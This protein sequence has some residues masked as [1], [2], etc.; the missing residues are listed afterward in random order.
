MRRPPRIQ[1][2]CLDVDDTLVDFTSSARKALFGMIGRDDMWAVWQQMTD[3][4]VARVVAGEMDFDS[5]RRART[6]AFLA[7]LGAL[8]DDEVVTAIEDRR[9]AQ[10]SCAWRLFAD[11]VPCLVWLRSA[12][13]RVAA[14]TNASGSQQRTKLHQLGIARFFDTI[15]IAGE[16]GVS[17][18][19]PMIFHA[20]CRQLDVPIE[21]AM[22]VGDRLDI[23][24]VGANNAGLH[25]VWLHRGGTGWLA[26][27]GVP[28][29]DSLANLPALLVSEYLTPITSSRST[30]PSQ[31]T[32]DPIS[33]AP[34][35]WSTITVRQYGQRHG[36]IRDAGR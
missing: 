31:R 24:A 19:D 13:L 29:I 21:Q 12:G 26:P 16:F 22:H 1:A 6:K 33:V 3:E 14:V 11:V 20:A 27:V 8:L 15:V 30:V 4:Y 35:Q 28:V 9:L 17:K 18:P 25:G 7:D 34:G 10:M 36:G 23:D 2:V 5:M 32:P